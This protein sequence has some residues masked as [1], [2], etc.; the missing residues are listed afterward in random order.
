MRIVGVNG[1]ATH[2]EGSI[3]VLLD[4][5]VD[6]GLAVVDVPLPMR[7]WFSARWGGCSDGLLVAQ[8]ARDGDV[9]VAHSFG[10]LRAWNAHKVRDFR[11]VIC[12]APAMS[13]KSQW[14]YPERVFCYWSPKDW[15]VRIGSKL[16]LH[17]FGPAGTRGFIQDGVTN[18]REECGHSAYFRGDRLRELADRIERIAGN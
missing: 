18:I 11:A 2:G 7:H 12:I 17:P 8:H 1:I 4:V 13:H 5:L 3:D 15:A 9:I 6:R 16:L 10:C 14:R